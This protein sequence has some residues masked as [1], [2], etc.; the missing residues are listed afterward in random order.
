EEF[1]EDAA[2]KFVNTYRAEAI[3]RRVRKVLGVGE[4]E[5]RV[6]LVTDQELAPDPFAEKARYIMFTNSGE[7]TQL[8]A[9]PVLD[10]GYWDQIDPQRLAT[11]KQRVR[12]ACGRAAGELL[13]LERCA[14][15]HCYLRVVVGN[16]AMLDLMAG[17]CDQHN[18]PELQWKGF[19]S[20]SGDPAAVQNV[21]PIPP[22][23]VDKSCP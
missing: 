9:T 15:R 13:G 20:V 12:A 4:S 5:D 11:I 17:V 14:T 23:P 19:L 6:V 1:W 18:A 16:P 21:A 8:V 3:T 10:P 7:H 2:G 22:F